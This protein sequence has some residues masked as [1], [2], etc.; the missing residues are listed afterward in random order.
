MRVA[1]S[2]A[3]SSALENEKGE[4]FFTLSSLIDADCSDLSMLFAKED[5]C[6]D[7]LL[8]PVEACKPY[9]PTLTLPKG[10]DGRAVGRS[11]SGWLRKYISS[12]DPLGSPDGLDVF[13]KQD[14]NSSPVANVITRLSALSA[15]NLLRE[16][17][18]S[19]V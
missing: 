16:S 3:M 18:A 9:I 12:G 8:E 19:E 4:D 5:C 2:A 13:S 17:V 11:A 1:T 6:M 7:C 15:K 10:G 14:G